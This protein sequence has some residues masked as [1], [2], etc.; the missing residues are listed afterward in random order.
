MWLEKNYTEK[1]LGKFIEYKEYLHRYSNFLGSSEISKEIE[2]KIQEI[3][4]EFLKS[5]LELNDKLDRSYFV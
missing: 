4:I 2:L 5:F 3:N 1:A